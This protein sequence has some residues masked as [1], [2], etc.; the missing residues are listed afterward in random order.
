MRIVSNRR[1]NAEL[2]RLY[3]R[4][5]DTV[6][7]IEDCIRDGNRRTYLCMVGGSMAEFGAV[8]GGVLYGARLRVPHSSLGP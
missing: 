3:A 1:H 8:A 5:S 7:R 6:N 2:L 4:L